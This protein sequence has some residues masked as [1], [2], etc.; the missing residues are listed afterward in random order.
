MAAARRGSGD[1]D[2]DVFPAG[3]GPTTAAASR[4]PRR[5]MHAPLTAGSAPWRPS[6]PVSCCSG[7]GSGA[8]GRWSP[9]ARPSRRRRFPE[10]G[11]DP[12]QR[13]FLSTRGIPR[14]PLSRADVVLGPPP[15]AVQLS[16]PTS[17]FSIS[18]F[19]ESNRCGVIFFFRSN[20]RQREHIKWK[21]IRGA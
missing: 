10:V 5:P 16:Q 4:P 20:L 1:A 15:R 13:P 9:R 21:R 17:P 6:P 11:A 7:R 8:R 12:S 2:A 3:G 19:C 18:F 14:T